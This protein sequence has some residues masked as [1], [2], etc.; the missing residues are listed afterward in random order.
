MIPFKYTDGGRS[1]FFNFKADDCVTRAI[2]IAEKLDYMSA[3][4]L[5]QT[6]IKNGNTPHDAVKNTIVRKVLNNLGYIEVRKNERKNFKISDVPLDKTI[7][8]HVQKHI[9]VLKNGKTYDLFALKSN[10]TIYG[11]WIKNEKIPK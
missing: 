6:Y 4:E 7:I 2:A 5:V 10:V 11:Y 1:I 9:C 3:F 8:I